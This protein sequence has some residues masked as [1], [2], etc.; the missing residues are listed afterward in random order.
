LYARKT[1]NFMKKIFIV[2]LFIFSSAVS[3]QEKNNVIIWNSDEGLQRL[4]RSHYKNDFYQLVNFYQPQ[5]NPF[6]CSVATSVIILNALDYGN[7]SSQKELEVVK[8]QAVGGDVIEWPLYAQKTFLN[9]KTD[10]IKQRKIIELQAPKKIVDGKEI[11]DPGMTIADLVQILQKVY[12]LKTDLTYAKKNDEKSIE[13]FRAT[14]KKILAEKKS[15]LVI[16]FDGKV[17]GQKTHGHISPVVAYDESSDSLLILDVALHKNL[18]YFISLPQLFAAM[19][20]KD[21]EQYRGYLVVSR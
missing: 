17:L 16:N 2:F 8:P 4:E 1:I 7:I 11:Y 3:A 6:F 14:A 18:W 20:T 15:F 12:H 13:K 19:N 10:K 5:I 9:E 21:G